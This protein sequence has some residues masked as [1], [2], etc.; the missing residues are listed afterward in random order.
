MFKVIKLYHIVCDNCFIDGIDTPLTDQYPKTIKDTLE[1]TKRDYPP[2]FDNIDLHD[3][4]AIKNQAKKIGWHVGRKS[5]CP[6][7]V[8]SLGIFDKS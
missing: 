1:C 6:Q 3:K 8:L 2:A 4:E 7:C 5:Y